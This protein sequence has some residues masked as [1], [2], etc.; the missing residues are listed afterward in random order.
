M[1]WGSGCTWV[2]YDLD[3]YL[4]LFV[5]NYVDFDIEHV[6]LPGPK[7]Q[8]PMEG[9]ADCVWSPRPAGGMNIL[10]HN[11]GD[12]TFHRRFGES[13]HSETR[14]PVFAAIRRLRL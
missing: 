12:G 10:Y 1:R 3:G 6:P 8:L 4:D 2:D 11:N 14:P 5:C 9:I 7:R 13:R